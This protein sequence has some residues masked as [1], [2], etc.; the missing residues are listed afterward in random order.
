MIT[1]YISSQIMDILAWGSGTMLATTLVIAVLLLLA[2]LSRVV[3]LRQVF[4]AK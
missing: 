2:L 1:E 4:G 3:D